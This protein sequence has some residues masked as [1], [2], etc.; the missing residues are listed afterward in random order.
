MML[1]DWTRVDAGI[2]HHFHLAWIAEMAKPLNGGLLPQGYYALGEQVGGGG[3]PDVLVLSDDDSFED[4]ELDRSGGLL[5]APPA[6]RLVAQAERTIYTARQRQLAIRHTSD[7]RVIALIEIVSSG[8]KA[9]SYALDTFR[10]KLLGALRQGVH[11]LV[12]DVYPPTKRDPGGVHG[13]VWGELTGDEFAL[14]PDADRTLAAY[15]AGPM[16]TAYVEP[17]T[18][19]QAL[20]EMPL[21]LTADGVG[22]VNVPLEMTY[23]AAFDGLPRKYRAVLEG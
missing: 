19:G 2:F 21:F 15:S 20:R 11:L 17:T 8:N 14:P 7:D 12:L 16:R 1:H 3:N 22:Y 5:T 4:D 10:D 13:T 6:T 18:V 23:R 9:S